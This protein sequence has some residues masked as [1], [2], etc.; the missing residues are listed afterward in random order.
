MTLEIGKNL[1]D[2]LAVLVCVGA[3]VA[4]MWLV[5]RD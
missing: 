2:F 3:L 1:S 4:L 5:L